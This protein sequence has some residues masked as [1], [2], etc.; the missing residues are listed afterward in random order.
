MI[1]RKLSLKSPRPE[2]ATTTM[3]LFIL[4][5][6]GLGFEYLLFM[7]PSLVLAGELSLALKYLKSQDDIDIA[8]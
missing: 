7:L 1:E 5:A 6:L 4:C 8:I 3:L 2:M